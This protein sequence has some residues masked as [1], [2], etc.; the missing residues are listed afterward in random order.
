MLIQKCKETLTQSNE[1]NEFLRN[2][3]SHQCRLDIE[4]SIEKLEN[5]YIELKTKLDKLDHDTNYRL[6]KLE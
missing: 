2:N 3:Y 5:N 6:N 1:L 4:E